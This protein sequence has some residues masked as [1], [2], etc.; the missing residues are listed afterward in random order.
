MSHF[1]TVVL[2][3]FV[4]IW[5]VFWGRIAQKKRAVRESLQIFTCTSI[6]KLVIALVVPWFILAFTNIGVDYEHYYDIIDKV[7]W[8]DYADY[9]TWEPFFLLMSVF[10]KTICNGNPDLV[11]FIYKTITVFLIGI[12]MYLLRNEVRLWLSIMVYMMLFY[13]GSFYLIAMCLASSIVS[14]AVVL[15]YKNNKIIIPLLLILVAAQIHNSMYLFLPI[16]ILAVYYSK[17]VHNNILKFFVMVFSFI[18]AGGLAMVIF[19][20]A[21]GNIESFHYNSY[22]D[23]TDNGGGLMFYIRFGTLSYIMYEYY[24]IN[25][26]VSDKIRFFVVFALGSALFYNMAYTFRVIGRMDFALITFYYLF[27]P[28]MFNKSIDKA[29]LLNTNKYQAIN[30]LCF[31][32]LFFLGYDEMSARIVD[33]ISPGLGHWILFVPF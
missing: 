29:R 22:T 11:I 31:V 3:I 1:S 8:Y 5:A 4:I 17:S 14:F 25:K 32:F 6:V 18:A 26:D 24:K 2:Y 20:W 21:A 23:L 16:F 9:F 15:W 10:L 19:K 28:Y 7:T 12:S 33:R 30:L 27:L 13:F